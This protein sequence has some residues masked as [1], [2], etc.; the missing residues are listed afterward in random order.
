MASELRPMLVLIGLRTSGKSTV[1]RLVAALSGTRLLDLD[2]E[3]LVAANAA[4]VADVFA[5]RGEAGF[6]ALEVALLEEHIGAH[7]TVLALGGGTPTAPGARAIIER[8][9]HDRTAAVVYLRW[10]ASELARRI[11]SGNEAADRPALLLGAGGPAP[12]MEAIFDARDPDYR[13]LADLVLEE[14]G[15]PET[16]AAAIMSWW[17]EPPAERSG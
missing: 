1:G 3:L 6:R 13:D 8:A 12:E 11:A 14:P 5:E 9:Q 7:D 16:A 15:D 2:Q 4:S 17:R 10:P